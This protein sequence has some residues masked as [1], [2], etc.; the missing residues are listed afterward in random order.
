MSQRLIDAEK[1]ID[2]IHWGIN[3]KAY[4]GDPDIDIAVIQLINAQPTIEPMKACKCGCEKD[5]K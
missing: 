3:D 2:I 1:L 4:F 5:D